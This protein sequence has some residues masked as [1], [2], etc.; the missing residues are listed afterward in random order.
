[1]LFG[2]G[3]PVSGATDLGGDVVVVVV[4]VVVDV[5]ATTVVEVVDAP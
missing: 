5:D 4:V 3:R 1:L 2:Y